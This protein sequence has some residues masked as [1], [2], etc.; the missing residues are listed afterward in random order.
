[1]RLKSLQISMTLFAHLQHLVL[2]NVT[3]LFPHLLLCRSPR[4]LNFSPLRWWCLSVNVTSWRTLPNVTLLLF[5]ELLVTTQNATETMLNCSA[6]RTTE[7]SSL[8]TKKWTHRNY[9][10]MRFRCPSH[11]RW[12][13]S[14]SFRTVV[15][16]PN[17]SRCTKNRKQRWLIVT[18]AGF[19]Y[20]RTAFLYSSILNDLGLY[21]RYCPCMRYICSM[22]WP[23]ITGLH[24][25]SRVFTRLLL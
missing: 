13:A 20:H 21:Q 24:D 22:S 6:R 7:W 11:F 25:V 12:V 10:T 17:I 14:N 9:A 16:L 15:Q 2:Q 4:L 18:N 5:T 19:L 8:S 1:M 3:F 23:C